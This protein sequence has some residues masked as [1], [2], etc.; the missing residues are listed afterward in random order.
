[1]KNPEH[2]S[3]FKPASQS[4]KQPLA[5]KG[6]LISSC[7]EGNSLS[8]SQDHS[9]KLLVPP[10]PPAPFVLLLFSR[11]RAFMLT[12]VYHIPS[13]TPYPYLQVQHK[14]PILPRITKAQYY[15]FG[16][17]QVLITFPVPFQNGTS[18]L[19]VKSPLLPKKYIFY[20]LAPNL[21]SVLLIG[22][23][24]TAK[25]LLRSFDTIMVYNS[26]A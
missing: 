7:R 25:I 26:T 2:H 16:S 19:K 5:A 22:P 13:T 15:T 3:S 18:K 23:G 11:L 1:M 4:L 8:K 20:M 10:Q 17:C 14:R 24:R 12:S 6:L 9:K 21:F